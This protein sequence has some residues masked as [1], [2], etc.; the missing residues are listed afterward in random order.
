M[1]KRARSV[2]PSAADDVR[3]PTLPVDDAH[4]VLDHGPLRTE[5]LGRQHDLPSRGDD[6][7]DDEKAAPG[8]LAA[9][10]DLFG[11]VLLRLLCGRSTP[12]APSPRTA[13]WP[14]GRRRAPGRRDP[15]SRPARAAP[16]PQRSRPAAPGRTRSGTCRSSGPPC[17]RSAGRTCRSGG[18][19]RRRGRP[20]SRRHCASLP[21]CAGWFPTAG[22]C[23]RR[24]VRGPTGSGGAP[25]TGSSWPEP[26]WRLTLGRPSISQSTQS[27]PR[28]ALHLG[29]Q[30]RQ[31]EELVHGEATRSRRGPT[32]RTGGARWTARPR[33]PG[34]TK[35]NAPAR[36][37]SSASWDHSLSDQYRG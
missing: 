16:G 34:P 7:L 18:R 5:V 1:V 15:R 23:P 29:D 37:T 19:R 21:A 35:S 9:F 12:A 32:V 28:K 10:A 30:G 25:G 3:S 17:V 11:A 22:W 33:R 31:L 26:S 36:T 2:I 20:T 27:E 24:F 13:W 6:V 8:H 14:R 4:R